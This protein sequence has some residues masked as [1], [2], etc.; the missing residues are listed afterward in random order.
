MN[1]DKELVAKLQNTEFKSCKF[2]SFT[3]STLTT[4]ESGTGTVYELWRFKLIFA[5]TVKVLRFG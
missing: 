2:K 5:T 4:D 1:R 3:T